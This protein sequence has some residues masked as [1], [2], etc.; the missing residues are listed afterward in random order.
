MYDG[1]DIHARLVKGNVIYLGEV[2][3]LGREK[4]G[5]LAGH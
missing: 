4:D 3:A 2:E 5:K 1:L